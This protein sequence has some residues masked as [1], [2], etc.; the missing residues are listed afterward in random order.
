VY[1]RPFELKYVVTLAEF[2]LSTDIHVTNPSSAIGV[3]EFQALLHTYH[4]VPASE[5][6]ISP[7]KGLSYFDKTAQATEANK[8]EDRDQVD[9]KV[10]T[11]SVYENAGGEYTLKWG[12][13]S[14]KIRAVGFK[15]VVVWNPQATAGSKIGDMEDGGWLV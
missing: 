3:L 14:A 5:V 8:V 11:D 6:Q 9:V 1:N 15:D 13:Q 2:Q 12:S 7:L 10:F 4:R